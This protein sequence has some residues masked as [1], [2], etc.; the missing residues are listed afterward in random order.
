MIRSMCL[1]MALAWS[2]GAAAQAAPELTL[3]EVGET[4][5][6]ERTDRAPWAGML[7][8][9][10]D[11]FALQTQILQLQMQ[12]QN[13]TTLHAETLTGRAALLAEAAERCTDR[14]DLVAGLWRE[15]RDEL[16]HSLE[17]S[18]S[19]EGAEWFEHPALWFALGAI[20]AGALSVGVVSIVGG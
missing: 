15:R 6:L 4:V 17:V 19:H 1:M 2:T 8:R 14:V 16:A 20:V 18:R 3:P 12:I 13:A 7:V 5:A 9:D 10:E 11:L